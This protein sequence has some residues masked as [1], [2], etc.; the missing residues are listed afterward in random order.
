MGSE[1]E[2]L[3]E[4]EKES[5]ETSS[6]A[7]FVCNICGQDYPR[8]RSLWKHIMKHLRSYVGVGV[9]LNKTRRKINLIKESRG[10]ISC[11]MCNR[12]MNCGN[13]GVTALK[14]RSNTRVHEDRV[15]AVQ[16]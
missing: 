16:I 1:S 4:T 10:W 14:R 15:R 5:I 11:K 8:K 7:R 6:C 9:Q 2:Q 12:D 3:N 13:D